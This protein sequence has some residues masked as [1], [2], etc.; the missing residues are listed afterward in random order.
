MNTWSTPTRYVFLGLTIGFLL[1]ILWY[2]RD[3]LEPLALA[4]LIAYLLNPLVAVLIRKARMSHRLAGNLVYFTSLA[5]LIAIPATLI[6]VLFDEAQLLVADLLKS[7]EGL[8]TM[9]MQPIVIGGFIVHMETYVANLTQSLSNFASPLPQ[10]ALPFL[11]RTSKG[12]A[13]LLVIIVS[14]YYFLMDWEQAIELLIRIAP[15]QYQN[16]VRHLYLDITHVWASYLR[17]Q[18]TLM[19]IV[20]VVFTIAW[21]AIGLP[22]ALILGILTGLFSLVPD[23]GP[24]VGAILA[25]IVALLDGSNFLRIQNT[26]FAV[27][28]VGIYFVL[29]NIKGIWLRPRIMGRSV[30]MNEGVVF[31]AIIAAVVFQG[32]FGALIVIP[33]MASTLVVMKYIRRR[34]L[35]LLPFAD[36]SNT[37]KKPEEIS[38]STPV[39]SDPIS[40]PKETMIK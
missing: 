39:T 38:P 32:V 26:W 7:L 14:V 3:L 2:I 9:L 31:V 15:R 30:H 1:G 11:E 25:A 13:W 19:L 33:V 5:V 34:V 18:L 20:G 6:P 23:V 28:V 17:G 29:I 37:T 21:V 4:V 12:T 27:L 24:L 36:N 35:G 22:G 8:R 10:N 40:E 16:D